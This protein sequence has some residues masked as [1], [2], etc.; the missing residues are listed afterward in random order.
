MD[1]LLEIKKKTNLDER[2]KE[3]TNIGDLEISRLSL[4][5]TDY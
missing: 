1:F 2:F 3:M 4:L 5:Q